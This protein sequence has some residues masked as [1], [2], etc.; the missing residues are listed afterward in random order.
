LLFSA[1]GGL[2]HI[3]LCAARAVIVAPF[4]AGVKIVVGGKMEESKTMSQTKR[5]ELFSQYAANL[6]ILK[7]RGVL[8]IE[9]DVTDVF[10]CPLCYEIFPRDALT[11]GDNLSL[12]HVPPKAVGGKNIGCTLTCKQCNNEA[13]RVL[14]SAL[15]RKLEIDDFQARIPGAKLN[16][17]Y[18]PG[19]GLWLPAT[20]Y[21]NGKDSIRVEN[22]LHPRR[23]SPS[24]R[25]RASE[26]LEAGVDDFKMMHRQ[27]GGHRIGIALLRIAYLYAFR[28]LGYGLILHP[29]VQQIQAQLRAPTEDIIPSAW[30]FPG[31]LLPETR[32]GLNIIRRPLELRSFVVSFD[33]LTPQ[34]QIK[35]Y[36]VILPIPSDW[37]LGVYDEFKKRAGNTELVSFQIM[38]VPEDIKY[39][40]D[41]DLCYSPVQS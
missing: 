13:G 20:V 11:E 16:V 31:D 21:A 10:I 15:K 41:P 35:S 26:L 24:D 39:L 22:L 19:D 3:R 4:L 2:L 12:E 8:S 28:V 1:G 33:L 34:Q 5:E 18:S 7:R 17:Q 27:P 9:P 30:M 36:A 37:G 38:K 25:Q 23:S 6:G 14:D 40:T 29:A 32:R